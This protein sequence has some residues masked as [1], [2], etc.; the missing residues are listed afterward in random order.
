VNTI[1][2]AEV[3]LLPWRTRVGLSPNS[4]PKRILQKPPPPF[5][6]K[7]WIKPES[8]NWRPPGEVSSGHRR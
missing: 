6:T 2:A 8:A 1:V 3:G 4:L 5:K 7:S